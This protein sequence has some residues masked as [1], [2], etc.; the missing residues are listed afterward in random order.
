MRVQALMIE[1]RRDLYMDEATGE[2][3]SGYDDFRRRLRRV[4]GDPV[5]L[6][7]TRYERLAARYHPDNELRQVVVDRLK[8]EWVKCRLR[9]LEEQE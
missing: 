4:L 6:Y 7:R 3:L 5:H 1:V 9:Q 8:R 2:K